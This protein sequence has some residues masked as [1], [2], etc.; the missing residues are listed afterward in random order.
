MMQPVDPMTFARAAESPTRQA[1][2]HARRVTGSGRRVTAAPK[3][4]R[5]GGHKNRVKQ[6]S[7]MDLNPRYLPRWGSSSARANRP[8]KKGGLQHGARSSAPPLESRG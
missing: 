3:S 4:I 2:P 7:W 6:L 1:K 8:D 5:N